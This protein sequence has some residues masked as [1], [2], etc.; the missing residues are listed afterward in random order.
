MS[1]L[2]DNDQ[3][4]INDFKGLYNRT[5]I[6]ENIPNGYLKTCTDTVFVDKAIQT[7]PGAVIAQT[8]AATEYVRKQLYRLSTSPTAQQYIF[9]DDTGKFFDPIAGLVT[10]ILDLGPT[11]VD[12]SIL[13]MFDRVYISPHNRIG[14]MQSQFVYVWEPLLFPTVTTARLAGGSPPTSQITSVTSATPGTIQAGIHLFAVVSETSSG[15]LTP[16]KTSFAGG[17]NVY[18][19]PGGFKVDLTVPFGDPGTVK[20]HI[21]ATKRI[22]SF[23][24]NAENYEFFFIAEIADNV[25]AGITIDFIDSQLVDSGD[26]LLDQLELI[27]AY[28]QLCTYQGCV[29]GVGEYDN[30]SIARISKP[31]EPESFQ[32][33]DGFVIVN[34]G[35]S[36]GLKNCTEY[37]GLLYL[38]KSFK[39]Y[40]TVNNGNS[41]N[42]WPV[43]EV[44]SSLGTEC[45]GIG[46]IFDDP[47]S[48]TNDALIVATR[49]GL[50]AFDGSYAKRMLSWVVET[51]WTVE[52]DFNRF[53]EVEVYTDPIGKSV[54][55]NMPG[56]SGFSFPVTSM[57]YMDFSD[58]LTWDNV[59]WARWQFDVPDSLGLA[60]IR[61]IG[62]FFDSNLQPKFFAMI[63][64]AVGDTIIVNVNAANEFGGLASGG[65]GV[66][67]Q[68]ETHPQN[69]NGQPTYK[70]YTGG[71]Y[72]FE[73]APGA[74]VP[75]IRIAGLT[76]T[77]F[78]GNTIYYTTNV[79]VDYIT[80]IVVITCTS[81]TI[82]LC[83]LVYM[84]KDDMDELPA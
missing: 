15:F 40:S 6:R 60:E 29:V 25:T 20:R 17:Y 32:A 26:F 66:I 79:T 74:I 38:F 57:L 21:L 81:G 69:P 37:R 70:T 59:R 19:A 5:A 27:P 23:D 31:G 43:T 3:Y 11:C 47:N 51:T 13:T 76:K 71:Y 78:G 75:S 61:S 45:F 24:G 62:L 68:I 9:L 2:R 80:E 73:T 39:T 16:Y 10:P 64:T 67:G 53:N 28:I 63:F 30:R 7:R 54:Y 49:G 35:E 42:A 18:T 1:L 82:R 41:P 36:G 33:S 77:T 56:Y 72:V 55:I 12:F 8:I 52:N 44:D 14:G 83:K 34:P 48:I 50:A 46:R 4:P 58:G 22:P 84:Y 65:P